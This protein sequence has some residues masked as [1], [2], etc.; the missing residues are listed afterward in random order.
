V[1]RTIIGRR[2]AAAASTAAARL[3]QQAGT[4]TQQPPSAPDSYAARLIKLIPTEVVSLYVTVVAVLGPS[5]PSRPIW[6]L[7]LPFVAGLLGTPFHLVVV[8]RVRKI[9]QIVLSTLAFVAWVAS[10]GGPLESIGIGRPIGAV[11]LVLLTFV[12][13]AFDV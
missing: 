3:P 6:E 5:D 2:E 12:L 4:T 1:N 8:G 13:P 10:L 7:W 11:F 9:R